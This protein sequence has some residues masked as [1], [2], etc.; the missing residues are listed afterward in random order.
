M[1]TV[2]Y[3]QSL[4]YEFLLRAEEPLCH[5]AETYGNSGI[6][7]RRKRRLPDGTIAL[8]PCITGDALRHGLREAVAEVVLGAAGVGTTGLSEG[9]LRLLYAGGMITGRG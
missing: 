5:L 6:F 3:P 8:L 4:R 7:M 1:T 9:A 2:T